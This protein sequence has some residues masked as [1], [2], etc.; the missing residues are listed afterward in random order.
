MLAIVTTPPLASFRAEIAADRPVAMNPATAITAS[1]M[2][3][4]VDWKNA[5]TRPRVS[6]STSSPTIVKPVG[7]AVPEMTPI[8]NTKIVTTA[9]LGTSAIIASGTADAV[10]VTPNSRRREKSPNGR[11]PNPMPIARPIRIIANTRLNPAEPPLSVY[12]M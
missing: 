4:I 1:R 10:S 9:R 8:R 2:A 3:W 11:L 5:N 6:S 7:Y 12:W